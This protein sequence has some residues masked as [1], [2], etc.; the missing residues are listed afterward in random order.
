MVI[1]RT[2]KVD[3]KAEASGYELMLGCFMTIGDG[4]TLCMIYFTKLADC[5]TKDGIKSEKVR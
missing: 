5:F 4:V 1:A 3:L 2:F